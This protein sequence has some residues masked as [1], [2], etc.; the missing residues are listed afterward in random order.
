MTATESINSKRMKNIPRIAL[1]TSDVA[2]V[3][4]QFKQCE[5]AKTGGQ[6]ARILGE[7]QL[8]NRL[9]G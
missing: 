2:C 8:R 5:R 4:W 9:Q 1:G 3:A 6:A 7:R